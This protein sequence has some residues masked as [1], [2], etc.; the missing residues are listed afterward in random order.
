MFCYTQCFVLFGF[1]WS[2]LSFGVYGVGVGR[3][4][5]S[6]W[7]HQCFVLFGFGGSVLFCLLRC[8]CFV[9]LYWDAEVGWI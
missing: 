8:F 6:V 2:A 7:L 5:L 4:T 1:S 9:F 3:D